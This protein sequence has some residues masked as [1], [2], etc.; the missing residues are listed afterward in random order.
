MKCPKCAKTMTEKA[1]HVTEG[2]Y[3]CLIAR[4]CNTCGDTDWVY[5][6]LPCTEACRRKAKKR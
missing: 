6:D 1:L 4:R 2:T 3:V 5:E